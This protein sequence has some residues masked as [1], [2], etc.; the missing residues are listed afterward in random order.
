M[1]VVFYVLFANCHAHARLKLRFGNDTSFAS[2]LLELL[3]T[4]AS[5]VST[6]PS[7]YIFIGSYRLKFL[8]NSTN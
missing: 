2:I 5:F 4:T 8:V 6:A 1:T 7:T 3:L